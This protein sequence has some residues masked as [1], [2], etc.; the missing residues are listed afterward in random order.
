MNVAPRRRRKRLDERNV[1]LCSYYGAAQT[2]DVI[3]ESC[4]QAQT[5]PVVRE[6]VEHVTSGLV[7]KDVVSE[8]LAFYYLTLSRTRYMRDPRNVELVRAPWVVAADVL[9][10]HTPGLDCDDM[11]AF[12]CALAATSGAECRVTTVAFRDMFFRKERQFSHVFAQ[13]KEPRS[14]VWIT[15]D[16]VAAEKTAQMHRRIVAAKHWPIA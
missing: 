5:K 13:V 6:L 7:S 14:S 16:P 3:R 11:A 1:Q 8:A 10:G 15:L 2:I 12:L 4:R 9:A